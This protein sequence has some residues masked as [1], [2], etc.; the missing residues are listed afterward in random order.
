MR[1]NFRPLNNCTSLCATD[2]KD[3]LDMSLSEAKR[4]GYIASSFL[5]P[6][7]EPWRAS[8]LNSSKEH[9]WCAVNS[10]DQ[11]LQIDLG[12]LH[13]VTGV[14]TRGIPAGIVAKDSWVKEYRIQHSVLGD[15]WIDHK[16]QNVNKVFFY[17]KKLLINLT[18]IPVYADNFSTG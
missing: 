16:E 1:Y 15:T 2:C 7:F 5:G 3:S 9:G 4:G 18:M 10:S 6:S 8:L 11:F 14:S 12:T 17:G 13:Q